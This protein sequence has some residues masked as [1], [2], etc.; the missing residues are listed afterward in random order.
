MN[1]EIITLLNFSFRSLL[2]LHGV[3]ARLNFFS[4]IEVFVVTDQHDW[5]RQLADLIK[6]VKQVV[7]YGVRKSAPPPP[8]EMGPV[9]E[10]EPSPE[11]ALRHFLLTSSRRSVLSAE[12]APH[13]LDSILR[14]R[15]APKDVASDRDCDLFLVQR[16][17]CSRGDSLPG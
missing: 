8:R 14:A 12:H 9:L 5:N 17:L 13:I 6:W 2:A 10:R 1:V 7:A 16:L 3:L 11:K 15:F 4:R